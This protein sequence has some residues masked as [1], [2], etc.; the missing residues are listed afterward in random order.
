[1]LSD[2]RWKLTDDDDAMEDGVP[3]EGGVP[4][5]SPQQLRDMVAA[6][7]AYAAA[8]PVDNSMPESANNTQKKGVC[9]SYCKK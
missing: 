7:A 4:F 1:M 8:A 6:A 3:F 5:L 2:S 9:T